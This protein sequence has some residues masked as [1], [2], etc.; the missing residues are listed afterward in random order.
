M[1]RF[2]YLVFLCF[3]VGSGLWA[4]KSDTGISLSEAKW[5]LP[6]A[7][8]TDGYVVEEKMPKNSKY[9]EMVILGNKILNETTKYVGPQAKDKS[10]RFAGNNLSCSSCHAKGGS[11]ANQSGFVGIWGRFPQYNARADKVIT[12]EDRVNGCFERSMNGKRMPVDSIEMKAIMT[13]M[14]WLS[15]GIQVGAKT[16]GQ[17]L[18]AVEFLSRAADPKA[19]KKI[20]EE[21]CAACHQNNGLGMKN[22]EKTGSYYI[23]PPL[24]GDDSYNT[25]AG[26]Y[27]LIKAASY[28]KANMPQGDANLSLEEAYDVAAYI[29]SQKRPV[30]AN[31][32][33]DFPDLK[34]KPLDMDV[35][36]YDDN[37]STT[38]HRYGPYKAK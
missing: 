10:K 9:S 11:V 38:Q 13:Y 29:N 16:Q 36:P 8:D 25:G 27:R 1:K 35:G 26:M 7:L 15:Q 6:D 34:L 3:F 33:K 21:K 28:I 18:K 32:D 23:F 4:K 2:F 12:L 24:W 19:G 22:P 17:G 37:L 30:K 5:T 31:R 14:Q 20:Y